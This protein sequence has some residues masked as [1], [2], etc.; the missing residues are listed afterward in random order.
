MSFSDLDRP[1]LNA[2]TLSAAVLRDSGMWREVRVL[3]EVASTNTLLAELARQGEA[4]GL[5]I[6]AEAQSSGRGRLDRTWVSPARAGLTF[7]M[8]LRPDAVPMARW[9]WLPLLTGVALAEAVGRIADVDA[10]VKWPNDLLL[11]AGRR[12]AAGVLAEVAGDAVVVGVGLNVTTRAA[13]LP[14]AQATSLAIAGAAETDRAPLLRAVL[15]E[16]GR[17]YDEWVEVGGDPDRGLLAAYRRVCD[18]LGRPVRVSLPDGTA[19]E[20]EARDVDGEGR[21]VVAA[22]AG[23]VVVGAGDVV[24]VRAQ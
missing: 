22:A 6:V 4:A 8:L 3:A 19:L 23:D 21:L 13:E 12:K 18:T 2:R 11:G 17:L 1:P 15:R 7:S 20:G 24:H 16:T 14:H 10:W 9:G 5:V